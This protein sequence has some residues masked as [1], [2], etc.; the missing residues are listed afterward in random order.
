M[1]RPEIPP[2]RVFVLGSDGISS[3]PG[4]V[5]QVVAGE[6]PAYVVE[7]EN[8]D[9]DYVSRELLRPP[10]ARIKNG[11]PDLDKA[12]K[13]LRRGVAKFNRLFYIC[14]TFF[15]YMGT[16]RGKGRH[17]VFATPWP[18]DPRINIQPADNGKDAKWYQQ[19]QVR[20]CLI[21]LRG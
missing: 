21:R 1:S 4:I 3:Q 17:D 8:G 14:D 7:L 10:T 2:P 6:P 11:R 15:V 5:L 16:K 9:Y 18:D 20:N 19:K 13:E 12:I